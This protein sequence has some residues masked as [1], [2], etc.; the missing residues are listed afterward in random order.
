MAHIGLLSGSTW[1]E[2]VPSV[3]ESCCLVELFEKLASWS[4]CSGPLLTLSRLLRAAASDAASPSFAIQAPSGLTDSEDESEEECEEAG[5]VESRRRSSL[6]AGVRPL[7]PAE[8]ALA[9][10]TA[11]LEK[12]LRVSWVGSAEPA[13][14]I[15]CA[16]LAVLSLPLW[17]CWPQ[18]LCCLTLR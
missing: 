5:V 8:V 18:G 11:R 4:Q 6:G 7:S 13:Q 2:Y 1:A 15:R 10:L 12:Q 17:K 9:E 16:H 3:C 14:G